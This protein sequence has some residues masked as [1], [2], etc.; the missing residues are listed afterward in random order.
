[1]TSLVEIT[2]VGTFLFGISGALAAMRRNLDVFG[3]SFIACI[4][5]LG[6]STIRD[7]LTGHYP[8]VWVQDSR[9][10]MA[11]LLGVGVALCLRKTL[12]GWQKVV[13][14]VD[15]VGIGL[16]AIMGIQ[17]CLDLGL[18]PG[19]AVLFGMV[20]T[21]G[22]SFL[23]DIICNE[24]PIIFRQELS[25]TAVVVGGI[26]YI[27]FIKIGLPTW[28][29]AFV[30]IALIISIRLLSRKYKIALPIVTI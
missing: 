9:Y 12:S 1:M 27:L 5:A 22:G 28:I 25:A 8:L 16:F 24:V 18:S 15:T 4:S 10:I 17:N 29:T 26:I 7:V 2:L 20:S 6:G 3:I 13:F 11:A 30:P 14:V 23:R 21:I 19:V